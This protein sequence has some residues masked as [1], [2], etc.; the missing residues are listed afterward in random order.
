MNFYKIPKGIAEQVGFLQFA[1][2]KAIDLTAC[3]LINNKYALDEE[4][5]DIIKANAAS[6]LI[7]VPQNQHGR[8]NHIINLVKNDN[9]KA[10]KEQI[11]A[12]LDVQP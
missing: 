10:T 7:Y 9:D 4:T 1:P 12:D 3:K 8:I 11:E 5:I 2:G 6:I